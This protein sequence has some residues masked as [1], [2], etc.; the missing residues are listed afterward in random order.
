MS[1]D[2]AR[3]QLAR[4][5]VVRAI[6][7]AAR[8]QR[9]GIGVD[10]EHDLRLALG[11]PSGQGVAEEARRRQRPFTA[12]FRPLPAVKRGTREAAI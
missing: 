8:P 7:L 12:L 5:P 11:D 3:S 4:G 2:R 9:A 10:A 6:A 1:E